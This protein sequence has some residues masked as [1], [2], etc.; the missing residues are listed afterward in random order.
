VD[1]FR[2]GHPNFRCLIHT[3]RLSFLAMNTLGK[4]GLFL[5]VREIDVVK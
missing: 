2:G 3:I 1:I 5:L 4:G